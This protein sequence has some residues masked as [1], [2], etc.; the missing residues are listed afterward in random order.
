[1]NYLLIK[2]LL[3]YLYIY[4]RDILI[5]FITKLIIIL[6]VR[7]C[8][9]KYIYMYG[10]TYIYI[11][12]Y[13]YNYDPHKMHICIYILHMY[14]CMFVCMYVCIYLRT[15]V[16]TVLFQ[17]STPSQYYIKTILQQFSSTWTV[18]QNRT[19][20]LYASEQSNRIEKQCG[21][22]YKINSSLV[23]IDV[24]SCS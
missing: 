9:K 3:N 24:Y 19:V 1:M 18:P 13:R 14:V 6:Y 22:K 11:Y 5:M 7:M 21:K 2:I 10:H 20:D 23:S 8:V 15:E 12:I 4:N 17:N 16:V